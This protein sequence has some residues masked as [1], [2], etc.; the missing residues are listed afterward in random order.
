M[1]VLE[2]TNKQTKAG[3]PNNNKR[4]IELVEKLREER[5]NREQMAAFWEQNMKEEE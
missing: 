1:A 4:N 3:H 5:G 2:A